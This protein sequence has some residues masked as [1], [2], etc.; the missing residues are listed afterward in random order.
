MYNMSHVTQR[1]EAQLLA[2]L[3]SAQA[4]FFVLQNGVGYTF[5]KIFCDVFRQLL[6]LYFVP[7]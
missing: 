3:S 7:G 5:K 2:A 6:V 4:R 1:H